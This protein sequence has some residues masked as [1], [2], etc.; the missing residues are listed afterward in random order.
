VERIERADSFFAATGSEIVHGGSRAC[1]I[2]STDH[3]YMPCIDF[4]RDA[5]SYYATL[6]HETTHNADTRIMPRR[7]LR[8][9]KSGAFRRGSSA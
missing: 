8:S 3:I 6:A 9:P 5:E 1:Y 4:F 7:T 2:P